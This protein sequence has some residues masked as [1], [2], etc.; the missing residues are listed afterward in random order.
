M[1]SEPTNRK[2]HLLE[3][4]NGR[5]QQTNNSF[6]FLCFFLACSLPLFKSHDARRLHHITSR[7]VGSIPRAA[8]G[9]VAIRE[10][11]LSTHTFC[12]CR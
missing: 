12:S 1:V 8:V 5:E 6:S 11:A 10:R 7:A 3:E 4:E 9:L 2:N